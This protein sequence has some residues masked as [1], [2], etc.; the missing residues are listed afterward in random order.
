MTTG[1]G[2]ES[3]VVGP[4]RISSMPGS[5]FWI[6]HESGEGVEVSSVSLIALIDTFYE[7][8]FIR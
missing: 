4:Y 6:E 3:L 5:G 7:R 2:I 8:Y 1:S